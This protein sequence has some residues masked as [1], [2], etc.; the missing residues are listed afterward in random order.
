MASSEGRN[1]AALGTS[2]TA[3]VDPRPRS[4][5]GSM[6]LAVRE[7]L[8]DQI[9]NGPAHPAAQGIAVYRGYLIVPRPMDS[10]RNAQATR[11]E[12]LKTGSLSYIRFHLA[13][14]R[15][16]W[17]AEGYPRVAAPSPS[18]SLRRFQDYHSRPTRPSDR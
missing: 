18:Q 6:M 12:A 14:L 11:R 7:T 5:S 2:S 17:G 10:S 9:A 8:C 15:A 13:S 3:A 1:S 4:L 16:F